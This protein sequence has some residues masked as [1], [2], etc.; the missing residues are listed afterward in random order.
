MSDSFYTL[1]RKII[2]NELD[3]MVMKLRL[4]PIVY[5]I[6]KNL[7]LLKSRDQHLCIIILCVV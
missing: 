4:L 1:K 5:F 6:T 3:E 2:R 7:Y